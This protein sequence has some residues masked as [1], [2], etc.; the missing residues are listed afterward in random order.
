MLFNP[1]K[2]IFIH[3]AVGCCLSRSFLERLDEANLAWLGIGW[4]AMHAE[5]A[6]SHWKKAEVYG[7]PS[8]SRRTRQEATTAKTGQGDVR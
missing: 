2:K 6:F 8:T 3:F 7:P 5:L 4:S 1:S